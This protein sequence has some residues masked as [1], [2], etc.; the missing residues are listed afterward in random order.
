MR[1]HQY[2]YEFLLYIVLDYAFPPADQEVVSFFT[3]PVKTWNAGIV[4]HCVFLKHLF[5][6]VRFYLI[7]HYTKFLSYA[8]LAGAWRKDLWDLSA[9]KEL[10]EGAIKVGL[11]MLQ[12]TYLDME[13]TRK[14]MKTSAAR[15]FCKRSKMRL[16]C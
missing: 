7:E 6:A 5:R 11:Q 12:R 4:L 10:Y 14:Q 9:R 16:R 1:S 2:G 13:N 15:V 8:D 3:S